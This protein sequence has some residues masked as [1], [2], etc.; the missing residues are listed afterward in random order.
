VAEVGV[1]F[2]L[3][4]TGAGKGLGYFALRDFAVGE[5]VLV[6]RPV[7][8]I[9]LGDKEELGGTRDI[10]YLE[11]NSQFDALP[12][13]AQAAVLALYMP[14]FSTEDE[15]LVF[16]SCPVYQRFKRNVYGVGNSDNDAGL[17]VHGSRFNHSCIPNCSRHYVEDHGLMVFSACYAIR[18][19]TEITVCYSAST[20]IGSEGFDAYRTYM[21]KSWGF[22]CSCPVCSDLSLFTKLEMIVK[23][24]DQMT[25]LIS[26]IAE[27]ELS[28]NGYCVEFIAGYRLKLIQAIKCGTDAIKLC[29]V[30]GLGCSS[31]LLDLKSQIFASTSLC[32]S[33][34]KSTLNLSRRYALKSLECL[35]VELGGSR[36][37]PTL[38]SDARKRVENPEQFP[39]YLLVDRMSMM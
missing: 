39:D 3:R 28:N 17:F 2:E 9:I 36:V 31:N 34:Q 18:A 10:P 30:V 27:V 19:G 26:P 21:M 33:F 8:R 11:L 14:P 15:R 32:A 35:E 20:K 22:K 4:D 37:E 23:L 38:L 13:D 25:K 7:I 1:D 12:A 16:Q 5:K 6:E 29:D 24:V